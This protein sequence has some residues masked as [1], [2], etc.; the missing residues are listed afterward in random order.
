MSSFD[1]IGA[2]DYIPIP[3]IASARS[4][5]KNFVS[6]RPISF[7]LSPTH[8][9]GLVLHHDRDRLH[10]RAPAHRPS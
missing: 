2:G 6:F 7:F 4:R 9:E 10:E 5:K 1:I 8:A 3:S